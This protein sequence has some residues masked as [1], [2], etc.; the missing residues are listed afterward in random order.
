MHGGAKAPEAPAAIAT[1]ISNTG[2]T[3]TRP[4]CTEKMC[5]QKMQEIKAIVE[6]MCSK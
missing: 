2:F 4:K 3:P 6:Q 5:E 1:E